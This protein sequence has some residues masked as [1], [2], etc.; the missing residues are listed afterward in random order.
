MPRPIKRTK[1][2]LVCC[3]CDW[4]ADGGRSPRREPSES[5]SCEKTAEQSFEARAKSNAPLLRWIPSS[6]HST[7]LTARSGVAIDPNPP[8]SSLLCRASRANP[9]VGEAGLGA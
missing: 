8:S 7:T 1:Q 5:E 9:V 6:R 2:L 4:V 3:C